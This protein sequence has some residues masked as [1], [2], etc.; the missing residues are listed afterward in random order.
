LCCLASWRILSASSEPPR[1]RRALPCHSRA[2]CRLLPIRPGSPRRLSSPR[3]RSPRERWRVWGAGAVHPLAC[4]RGQTACIGWQYPADLQ[5][6]LAVSRRVSHCGDYLG[7]VFYP[8]AVQ[9]FRDRKHRLAAPAN[10]ITVAFMKQLCLP[11]ARIAS[12]K[13]WRVC[14]YFHELWRGLHRPGLKARAAPPLFRFS[15]ILTAG[16]HPRS[17]GR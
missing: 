7:F 1:D 3:R 8:V 9:Y 5:R 15:P 14:Y 13:I 12:L 16:R 6:I 17:A 4:G 2:R 10:G 11:G